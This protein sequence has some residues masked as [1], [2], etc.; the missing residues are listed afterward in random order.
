[1][2]IWIIRAIA[3][4]ILG[5]AT[6]TWFKKTKLGIWFYNKVDSIYKWAANKYNVKILTEEEKQMAKFPMLKKRL[7]NIEQQLKDIKK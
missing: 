7:N 1:M 5:N 3:G 4:S 2:L 6:A